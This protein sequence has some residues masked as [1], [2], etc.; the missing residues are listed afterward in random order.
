[1]DMVGGYGSIKYSKD[2]K[3]QFDKLVFA[4]Y[5]KKHGNTN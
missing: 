4:V 3:D 1:M 5:N 2:R